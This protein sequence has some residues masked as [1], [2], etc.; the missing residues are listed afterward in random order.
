MTDTARA[1]SFHAVGEQIAATLRD[2]HAALEGYAEGDGNPREL[3]KCAEQLHAVHG[4]LQIASI[5]GAGLLAKEME[6]T[7]NFLIASDKSGSIFD[8]GIE[9]LS[10]AMV[11]L[12]SYVERIMDGGR[13]IPLVM[14]PLLNDLRAARRQS[15]LSES[16]LMLLNGQSLASSE[17]ALHAVADGAGADLDVAKLRP[18]FQLGLLGWIKGADAERNLQRMH[19]VAMQLEA[20][21]ANQELHR[22]W[23]VV[24]GVLE[25]LA[26]GGLDASISLKR[27][28]GQVDREIK[29][30]LQSGPDDFTA[31]PPA[32]LVNNLLFYIAR[33]TSSGERVAALRSAYQLGDV[34][35]AEEQVDELR[36]SLAAPSPQLMK[37]VAG[38]ISED[39]GRAKDVLDIYVRTGM[40][41][42]TELEAQV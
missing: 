37:T 10:R 7:C 33:A 1:E 12:P 14:L 2:A 35:P 21:A 4:A 28:L 22:L 36:E 25:A 34:A 19:A 24:G 20:G 40:E 8:E 41:D 3:K 13:D 39:L 30:L 32:D 17:Q 26:D 6:A 38:A 18:Q 42:A 15:L 27:L 23:W 29:R 5:Y 9:A 11:Q 31:N 16:T